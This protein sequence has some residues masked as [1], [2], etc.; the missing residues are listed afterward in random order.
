MPK[1]KTK[2]PAELVTDHLRA[3]ELGRR[4]YAKSDRLLNEIRKLVPVGEE[5]EI[6]GGKKAMIKDNFA[7]QDKV[8]RSH[9]IAR[10]E[11]DVKDA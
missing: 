5:I 2:T 1:V 9:G 8:F 3:R 6:S 11:L 10:Y 7:S 4:H